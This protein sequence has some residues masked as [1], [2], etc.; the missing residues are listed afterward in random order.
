MLK[1][2]IRSNSLTYEFQYFQYTKTGCYVS[3]IYTRHVELKQWK[4]TL[5]KNEAFRTNVTKSAGNADL[6]TF[7]EEIFYE[8]LHFLEKLHKN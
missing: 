2:F 7:T 4:I 3:S 6:V 1:K 8:K 5:H